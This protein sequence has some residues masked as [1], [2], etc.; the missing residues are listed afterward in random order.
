M[1]NAIAARPARTMATRS[2]GL[3]DNSLSEILRE[4]GVKASI[5]N[6]RTDM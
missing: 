5:A 1:M 2:C 6:D 4:A 3:K